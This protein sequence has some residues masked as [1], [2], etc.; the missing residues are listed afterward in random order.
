MPVTIKDNI[1]TQGEPKPLGTAAVDLTPQPTDAPPAAR[2]R[3]A[4]AIIFAKTTMPDYGMLSSGLSSFHPLA[5][6]PWDL[7]ANPGGSSAGAGAAGAAGYG[8]LHL[9]TDIGGSVRL[10]AGWCGLFGLKPSAG[11]VP[12]D[13]PYI[14]RVAGPMTRTVDD[15]A[16]MMA[17]LS[18]P[19]RARLHEP[20]AARRSTGAIA[21]AQLEGLRIGL[22]LEI[23]CGA[24]PTPRCAPR[25]SA[26]RAISRP[27]G[28]MSS[29]SGRSSRRRCST[30]S[31]CSGARARMIDIGA[32][33][34]E[35]RDKV[36]P[37]IRAW[38][39]SARGLSGE[40]VF[41][42]SAASW[43]SPSAPVAATRGLRLRADADRADDRLSRRMA[44][45]ERRSAEPV[46]AYRLHRRLQHVGPAGGVD[47]LR[48]RQ[49]AGCRSGC[50]SSAAASTTSACW[51]SRKP[52]RRSARREMRPWPEP[53]VVTAA[54]GHAA[55]VLLSAAQT[56][57][58]AEDD[59]RKGAVTRKTNETEIAVE[60]DLDGSGAAENRHRRRLLRP[61][62]RSARA[63]FAHR[64]RRSRQGRPA[65]R[66]SPH[67][68]GRRHRARPG[69]ASRRSATSAALTRYADC[70]LPMDETLTR[71]AVDVSGRPF[72]VF[73]AEFPDGEDRNLRHRAGARVLPGV[74]DQRRADAAYRDALRRSTAIISP[75]PASRASRVRL[76]RRLRSTPGRPSRVPST[77]GAL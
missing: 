62:A 74:C 76:A 6:N 12:I 72:L 26:P 53:P 38:A 19:G 21:P 18:L 33:A 65:H 1:A 31:T 30:A 22:V 28:A 42:A 44:S 77:K 48:L 17:T 69:A 4:G 34:P 9:G 63:P 57:G 3:E 36:L 32:L 56:L 39:E 60:V 14:G 40:T 59:M 7:V 23:G 73:R 24:T 10:P 52:T 25:S 58:E 41:A 49:R 46:S 5:R 20:A 70:L 11:R 35:R 71:V 8:P 51:R 47:Q 64:H 75:N 45:P 2:L 61:Y 27:P 13:P 55:R 67:G 50:R 43:N 16:L 15:A 68:R 66:R 54:Y 37:F 29:R